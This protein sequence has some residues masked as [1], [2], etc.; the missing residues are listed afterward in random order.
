[1]AHEINIVG[2]GGDEIVP[3]VFTV[4]S[5]CWEEV[6]VVTEVHSGGCG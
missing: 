5:I 2:I 3:E 6:K 4:T 1:M